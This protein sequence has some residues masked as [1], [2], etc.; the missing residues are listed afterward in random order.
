MFFNPSTGP[1]DYANVITAPEPGPSVPLTD[2]PSFEDWESQLLASEP[3]TL[4]GRY[5]V[6]PG[7]HRAGQPVGVL[8]R[9][10]G[11]DVTITDGTPDDDGDVKIEDAEG[12]GF[13]VLP[14]FLS[15]V[16]QALPVWAGEAAE[17]ETAAELSVIL[18]QDVP[19]LEPRP[20]VP[21]A[22][23]AVEEIGRLRGRVEELTH[24]VDVGNAVADGLREDLTAS[25]QATADANTRTRDA[26]AAHRADVT[27][28]G[29]TLL[30][31]ATA[32]EWCRDFDT[33]VSNL[34]DH[35]TVELPTRTRT[36][37]LVIHEEGNR[38]GPS[39]SFDVEAESL[40]EAIEL[41][42]ADVR[43]ADYIV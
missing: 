2:R 42:Y 7:A 16:S 23:Y 29:E 32:R 27:L 10:V 40:T 20:V 4:S 3:A 8:D 30:S 6:Q 34:N 15:P 1:Y 19:I 9:L 28:I 26:L 25:R 39:E 31:E 43:H 35:L 37:T 24:A 11:R 22:E 21:D 12:A 18:G 41:A 13:Y 5:T 33:I 17:L 38:Y 14:E 36:F